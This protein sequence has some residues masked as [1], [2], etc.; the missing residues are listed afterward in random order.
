[1]PVKP[2]YNLNADSD[3][4]TL[5]FGLREINEIDKQNIFI[6]NIERIK[7]YIYAEDNLI[8]SAETLE[9]KKDV[10][11]IDK[12]NAYFNFN[13]IINWNKPKVISANTLNF[14][15]VFCTPK[16]HYSETI[17]INQIALSGIDKEKTSLLLTPSINIIN[18]SNVVFSVD[19]KRIYVENKEYLPSSE[20]L[21]IEIL[22]KSGKPIF[23]SNNNMNYFQVI[24]QVLP[25]EIGDRYIYQYT[26]NGKDNYYK[27][28]PQGDYTVLLVIPSIPKPHIIQTILEW[29]PTK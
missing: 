10:L 1:M 2:T 12:N 19:A 18:D 22:N 8:D 3:S 6:N 23:A 28:L 4:I 7:A 17:P 20:L 16:V 11:P 26:W 13:S 27:K 9:F 5:S 29:R 15:F 21:R 24:K 14:N 25:S